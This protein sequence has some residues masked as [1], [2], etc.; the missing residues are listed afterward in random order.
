MIGLTNAKVGDKVFVDWDP[1]IT[2]ERL[3]YAIVRKVGRIWVELETSKLVQGSL[4]HKADKVSG[5]VDSK[6][7]GAIGRAWANRSDCAEH[8]ALVSL[9][10]E[11]RRR[12]VYSYYPPTNLH[13]EQIADFLNLLHSEPNLQLEQNKKLG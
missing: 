1:N 3:S 2:K 7:D 11:L 5:W 10:H 9:W 8:K 4:T 12:I 13:G 6:S